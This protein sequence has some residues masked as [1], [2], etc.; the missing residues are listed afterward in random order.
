MKP[1]GSVSSPPVPAAE[2]RCDAVFINPSFGYPV[3]KDKGL[4]Y[5]KMCPPLSLAYGAAI[6]E[7]AGRRVR[8]IDAQAERLGPDEVVRRAAGAD[9]VF[10]TFR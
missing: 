1:N 9:R 8:M 7:A 3:I 10:I 5:T 4:F 2:A 6:M